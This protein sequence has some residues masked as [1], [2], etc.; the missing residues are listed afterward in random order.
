MKIGIYNRSLATLGGGERHSLSLAEHLAQDHETTF[1]NHEAVTLEAVRAKLPVDVSRVQFLVFPSCA[2]Q[3]LEK[4]TTRFDCFINASYLRFFPARARHNILMVYFPSPLEAGIPQKIKERL[5]RLLKRLFWLPTLNNCSATLADDKN[6][7]VFRT[8]TAISLDLPGAG[9]DYTVRFQIASGHRSVGR[10]TVY[11]DGR[12]HQKITLPPGGEFTD[13]EM[14]IPRKDTAGPNHLFITSEGGPPE[15][16][17]NPAALLLKNLRSNHPG[18]LLFRHLSARLGPEWKDRLWRVSVD[19]PSVRECLDTYQTIWT[20]SAYSRDWISRYWGRES[21]IINPPVDL[22]RLKAGRKGRRILSVGR[23]FPGLHNKKHA[24]LIAAF[25]KMIDQGLPGWELHL[26]GG[27]RNE[28][29]HQRYLQEL[30]AQSRGYPIFIHSDLPHGELVTLYSASSIYWHACGYG[31]NP[32]R[33]PDKFEHFGITTVESMASGC[34]PVVFDGGGLKEI[35][36]HGHN[37]FLWSNPDQLIQYTRRLIRD[38]A[39]I[40]ELS[41]TAFR[42]SRRFDLTRFRSRLSELSAAAGL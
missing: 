27:T 4:M 13:C 25:K 8:L 40:R 38:P 20:I 39:L 23:F 7:P 28:R 12:P 16:A 21:A 33:H 42:D 24:V 30:S 3:D 34:V 10:V 9:A 19:Q 2:A 15:V 41:A 5:A 36:R 1:I 37:G 32:L 17:A 26:V 35:V 29:P 11:L 6:E 14:M 18:Q 31:E 22:R